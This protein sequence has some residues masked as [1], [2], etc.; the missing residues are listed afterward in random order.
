[1]LPSGK[2]VVTAQKPSK[3]A[4][5]EDKTLQFEEEEHE[6]PTTR[7]EK[8]LPQPPKP[9]NLS[10]KGKEVPILIISN[11]IPQNVPFP[12]I[13]IQ[14]KKEEAEKDILDTFRKV[15]INIP[16]LDAIKQVPRFEHAML[17]LGASINIM[18]YCIY[19]SMNLGELKNDGVIIQLADRSNAYPKGV[20]EDV[21]VQMARTKIDVFTG[22]LT[23]EFDGDI[24]NFNISETIRHP[25][26]DHSCFSIDI[27]DSLAHAYFDN[28]NEDALETTIIQG[29]GVKNEG[30]KSKDTHGMDEE[31]L[32]VPT[33]EDKAE[34][35]VVLETMPSHVGYN[36]IVIAPEDQEKTTFTCP[37]GSFAYRRMPF[38]LCNAP[39]TFQ[40]CMMSIFSDYVE[41]IIEVFMDDFSIFGDSFDCCLN[42]LS[43]ILK[44]CIETNLVLNWEKCHFMVK[45]GIALGHIISEKGIEVD[46]SKIDLVRHLPSPTSVRE[47]RS[48]LE[49]AGF[50]RRFIKD[51]S[52]VSQL[53]CRLLKK[54]VTFYFNEQCKAAFNHLKQLLTTALIIVPPDWSLPFELMCDAFD[55]A[56]GAVLGQRKDKKLH[57]IYYASRTLNYAQLSY[58]TTEKELLAI[59][60]ALDKF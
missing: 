27:I 28:L 48:F 19:A 21:L 23:M 12:R 50:Y 39:A 53:L 6:Q 58:S 5:K 46:K 54:E 33:C 7:V 57:V 14:S 41:K 3:S 44:R 18:P 10:N 8:P 15:Q 37:F 36:Q 26:E 49:H 35:L 20:L 42:N 2:Q 32:V 31:F 30:A 9:S 45:Q 52:K 1:M 24:I 16:L 59:V 34:I 51:F 40:K 38:G 4:P 55:Y 11:D 13:F 22:T 47:V 17:D 29:M 43:L 56:L 60:F 25:L